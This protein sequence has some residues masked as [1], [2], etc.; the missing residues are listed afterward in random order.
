MESCLPTTFEWISYEYHRERIRAPKARLPT[1]YATNRSFFGVQCEVGES[2][3]SPMQNEEF[4]LVEVDQLQL[5][6]NRRFSPVSTVNAINSAQM[7][8]EMGKKR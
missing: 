3:H 4:N 2:L 6:C 8:V 1:L 7:P 5:S